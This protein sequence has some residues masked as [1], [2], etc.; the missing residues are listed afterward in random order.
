MFYLPELLISRA[1]VYCDR[2]GLKIQDPILGR[3][4]QGM[5]FSSN[6]QSAI[7]VHAEK[8]GYLREL[9]AYS[10]LAQH[11]V[12]EVRGLTIPKLR[13]FDEPLHIIEMSLVKPPFIVDFGGAYLDAPPSHATDPEVR[14][15]W[16]AERHEKF[17]RHFI[18]VNAIL[19]ELETR[20][21]I[22]LT[23]VHPGNIRLE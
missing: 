7:K 8:A 5:V 9:Q 20:Y 12:R 11:D 15:R 23:D 21:G 4:L 10:R 13:A 14:A 22:Y 18:S 16:M 19:A 17:E 3:G 2:L 6:H 1:R